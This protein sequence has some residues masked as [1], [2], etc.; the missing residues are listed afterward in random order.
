MLAHGVHG[1]SVITAITAQNSLGVQGI[2]PLPGAAVQS[3]FRSVVDDIGVDAIKIGMLGSATMVSCVAELISGLGAMVPVVVDPVGVSKHGDPLIDEDAR[4]ALIDDLLP[5]ATVITPNLPEAAWLAGLGVGA[6]PA[7]LA[8]ALLVHGPRWVLIKGGHAGG[9][10]S[11]DH[12]Q[13]IDGEVQTFSANRLTNQHTHG[14]GCTLASA[15]ACGLAAGLGVPEA[16]AA[17][18]DYVTGAIAGGFPLGAGIGPTDH[19][20]RLRSALQVE[21]RR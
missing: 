12:L 3:Q 7:E 4:A 1:M 21:G 13:S 15:L 16:T 19:L 8:A 9:D 17:A 6:P 5:V 18:K 20:W 10:R 14:T 11:I 2:W